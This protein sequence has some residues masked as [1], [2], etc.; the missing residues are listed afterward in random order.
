[1]LSKYMYMYAIVMPF[2]YYLTNLYKM[3]TQ[4]TQLSCMNNIVWNL[5]YFKHLALGVHSPSM[6]GEGG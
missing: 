1:M 4:V 5:A 3:V 6:G 2:I